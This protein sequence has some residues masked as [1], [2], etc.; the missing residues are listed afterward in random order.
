MFF[1]IVYLYCVTKQARLFDDLLENT[2]SNSDH[3]LI[4]N[5][6]AL[7]QNT[8]YLS[9]QLKAHFV[10]SGIISIRMDRLLILA[11]NMTANISARHGSFT[12]ILTSCCEKHGKIT[13]ADATAAPPPLDAHLTYRRDI[14]QQ[15]H[16]HH[17]ASCAPSTR[18]IHIDSRS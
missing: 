13:M 12:S 3:V 7:N 2:T 1:S 4:Q 5:Y 18:H 16:L 6:T 15:I 17:N 14:A 11:F 8:Q 9:S 10:L